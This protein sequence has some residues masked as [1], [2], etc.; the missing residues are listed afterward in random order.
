MN[1]SILTAQ[2]WKGNWSCRPLNAYPHTMPGV[3]RLPPFGAMERS[4]RERKRGELLE[5]YRDEEIG[6]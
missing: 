5:L 6:L 2:E 4:Y 1:F 3:E